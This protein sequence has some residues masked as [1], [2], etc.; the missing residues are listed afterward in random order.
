M[1]KIAVDSS[2][3]ISY[4]QGNNTKNTSFVELALSHKN[5]V[6]PPVVMS[7]LLSDSK[8]PDAVLKMIVALPMIEIKAGYW[9]RAGEMRSKLI[10]KKFKARLA[11]V[12]IAQSC[13]DA[14]LTLICNDNDFRHF[15][16]YFGLQIL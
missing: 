7:E 5:I 3:F 13:I 4:L 2:V 11:D 16:K 6:L 15:V 14:D 8:V 9:R 1:K 12:L 10:A